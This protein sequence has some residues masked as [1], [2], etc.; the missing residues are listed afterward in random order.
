MKKN[1]FNTSKIS[2]LMLLLLLTLWVNLSFGQDSI[3]ATTPK[4]TLVKGTFAGPVL[5]DNQTINVPNKSA[6]TFTFQHRFGNI[7]MYSD[8]YGLFNIS[9][10]LIGCSYVPVKNV[11]VG[12][13]LCSYNMTWDLSLKLAITRQAKDGS[14]PVSISYF[15]DMG[16]DSR[17]KVN[18][19]SGADRYT[20]FNEIMIARKVTKSF[21]VQVAPSMSYFNNVQ[22]YIDSKGNIKPMMENMQFAVSVI[23]RYKLTPTTAIIA[24]Y[25]QP[26]TQNTTNNPHPN[27]GGG[28]EFET[29]GHTFQLF[30]SNYGYCLPQYNNFLNQNDFSKKG[31]FLLG[32]NITRF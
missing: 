2:R 23:G 4:P 32:F 13:G 10:I 3:S 24:D 1:N 20:Y 6:L 16:I 21:S 30:I 18:F 29:S 12:F 19:V 28:V 31:G 8:G 9:S 26:L 22:G 7:N 17:N 14:W 11:E 25:D 15:G 5:I 27:I